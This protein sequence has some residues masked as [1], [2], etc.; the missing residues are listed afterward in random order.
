MKNFFIA[1]G[2]ANIIMVGVLFLFFITGN[3]PLL[4]L[5]II[6][7]IL[8]IFWAM[9]YISNGL[10]PNNIPNGLPATATVISVKQGNF[11]IK[12]GVAE[13]YSLVIDAEIVNQQ[14]EKWLAKI[15]H[16]VPITQISIFQPGVSFAVKYDPNNRSKVVIDQN[17][18]D[19]NQHVGAAGYSAHE[20]QSAMQSAPEDLTLRLKASTALLNELKTTGITSEAE[21]LETIIEYHNY[22]PSTNIYT[23]KIRVKNTRIETEL[24]ILMKAESDYKIKKGNTIYVKYDANN[25]RRISMTG[26]D[27]SNTSVAI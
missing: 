5:G 25:N 24:I 18:G 9:G 7:F 1:F 8:Y 20:V 15:K 21:I 3:I 23:L 27:K 6:T 26:T 14:G 16:T 2:G 4:I 11:K 12:I 19:G 10:G 13:Y 22:L 17:T